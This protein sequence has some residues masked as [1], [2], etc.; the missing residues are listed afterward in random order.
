MFPWTNFCQSELYSMA[1]MLSLQLSIYLGWESESGSRHKEVKA[2][3]ALCPSTPF[4]F[5]IC[6]QAWEP[7]KPMKTLILQMTFAFPSFVTSHFH[8]VPLF[9]YLTTGE[10][11]LDES[12]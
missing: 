7:Q 5:R 3:G 12:E 4:S 10:S 1:A 6:K 8:V 2:R 11:K 9:S